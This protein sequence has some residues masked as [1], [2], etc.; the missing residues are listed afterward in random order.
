MLAYTAAQTTEIE[1]VLKLTELHLS[2]RHS[3]RGGCFAPVSYAVRF[4]PPA[5]SAQ[6]RRASRYGRK[7]PRGRLGVAVSDFRGGVS[8]A[9]RRP[10]GGPPQRFL[11]ARRGPKPPPPARLPTAAGFPDRSRREPRCAGGW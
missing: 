5:L 4:G 3:T 10:S 11:A 7:R 1:R 8:P 9:A 6:R 2:P